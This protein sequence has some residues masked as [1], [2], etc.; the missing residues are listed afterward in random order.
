MFEAKTEV[1]LNMM[2]SD[3]WASLQPEIGAVLLL[4]V[5]AARL[6]T[7]LMKHGNMPYMSR[8]FL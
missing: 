2:K 6:L 8:I 1:R 4:G 7:V 3:V 5:S